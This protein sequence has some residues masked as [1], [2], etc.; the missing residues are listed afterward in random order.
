MSSSKIQIKVTKVTPI[1]D[2]NDEPQGLLITYEFIADFGSFGTSS[3][4]PLKSLPSEVT[5][6]LQRE[7]YTWAKRTR[8]LTARRDSVCEDA[9]QLLAKLGAEDHSFDFS[10]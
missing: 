2:G 1:F 9:E 4:F 8:S 5:Q 7:A 3:I 10:Y 6:T